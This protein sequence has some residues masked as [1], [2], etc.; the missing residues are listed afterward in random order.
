MVNSSFKQLVVLT[1]QS[2]VTVPA[3]IRT[4]A[5]YMSLRPFQY[6]FFGMDWQLESCASKRQLLF[7]NIRVF[8]AFREKTIKFALFFI[9]V[10]RF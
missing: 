3:T 4:A 9:H 1:S 2:R 5:S 8:T 7:R 10:K 6:L